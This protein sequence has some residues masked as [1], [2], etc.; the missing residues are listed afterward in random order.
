MIKRTK[1]K[2]YKKENVYVEENNKEEKIYIKYIDYIEY[3]GKRLVVGDLIFHIDKDFNCIELATCLIVPYNK[4]KGFFKLNKSAKY[5]I[6]ETEMMRQYNRIFE[7][8]LSHIKS[9]LVLI[10]E[11]SKEYINE[12]IEERG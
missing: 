9:N 2:F 11:L 1:E 10:N 12:L 6:I 8:V 4:P 7:C 5:E 3:T